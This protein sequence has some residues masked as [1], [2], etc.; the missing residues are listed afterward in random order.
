MIQEVHPGSWFFTIP[1]PHHC[2]AKTY[3]EKTVSL[4]RFAWRIAAIY[5]DPCVLRAR[6]GAEISP[7]ARP[8]QTPWWNPTGHF[9]IRIQKKKSAKYNMRTK[10]QLL[11]YNYPSPFS[12]ASLHLLIACRKSLPVVP[13][14]ESNSGLPYSKPT[15]YQ[16][17]HAA[18]S[19]V[20]TIQ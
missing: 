6:E 16:L 3:G 5:L 14:R 20:F 7:A 10:R 1:D 12:G 19:L 15:Y 8:V 17:S 18:P 4:I 11:Q 2:F 9:F 13:S